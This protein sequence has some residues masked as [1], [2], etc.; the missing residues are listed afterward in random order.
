MRMC[1]YACCVSS[2]NVEL[3]REWKV[4]WAN[5]KLVVA[6][7]GKLFMYLDRFYTPNVTTH[8]QHTW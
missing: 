8:P 2:Y 6:G 4:R 7:L 5:H 3:L 1:C